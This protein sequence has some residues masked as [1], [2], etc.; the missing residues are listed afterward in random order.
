[1]KVRVGAALLTLVLGLGITGCGSGPS[2]SSF[3]PPPPTGGGSTGATGSPTP[4]TWANDGNLSVPPCPDIAPFDCVSNY[5]ILDTTSGAT[6]TVAITE[7]SYMPPTV[8]LTD[9]YEIRVNGYD[10]KGDPLSSPY[11]AFPAAQ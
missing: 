5:S 1:M 2:T 10:G 6:V 4:L 3:A 9:S 11:V 8:N 7:T